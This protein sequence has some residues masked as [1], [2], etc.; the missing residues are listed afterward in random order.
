M[1]YGLTMFNKFKLSLSWK[2]T[3]SICISFVL[4][5]ALA[6]FLIGF[7]VRNYSRRQT[8]Q[9]LI[10]SFNTVKSNSL[11]PDTT[12]S[13]ILL[14]TYFD[15][16]LDILLVDL[17]GNTA[18]V[19]NSLYILPAIAFTGFKEM[20]LIE[21]DDGPHA[22]EY[23]EHE[24]QDELHLLIYQDRIMNSELSKL[25]PQRMTETSNFTHI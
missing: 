7:T 10:N 1:F 23:F 3:L 4:I 22:E 19:K 5:M 13:N 14:F 20:R 18:A 12:I 21:N 2:I 15:K 17:Q 25:S 8:E 6:S 9:L 24:G 16:T 11:D